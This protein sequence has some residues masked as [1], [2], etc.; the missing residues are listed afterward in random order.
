MIT[1]VC[2]VIL[3]SRSPGSTFNDSSDSAKSGSAPCITIALK[4]EYQLSAGRITSSPGPTPS[5]AKA[6]VSAAVPEVTARA[7]L[8]RILADNSFSKVSTFIGV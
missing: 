8:V 3:D 7:N 1:L 6:V 2:G 4:Q 5:A